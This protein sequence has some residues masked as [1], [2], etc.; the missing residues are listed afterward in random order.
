VQARVFLAR[1]HQ[2]R[3]IASHNDEAMPRHALIRIGAPAA[4]VLTAAIPALAQ[5]T[6]I[7]GARVTVVEKPAGTLSITLH[8]LRESPLAAWRPAETIADFLESKKR[9]RWRSLRRA[10]NPH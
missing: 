10:N 7:T 3:Q 4:L 1:L 9:E 8:N 2:R 5:D 6:A